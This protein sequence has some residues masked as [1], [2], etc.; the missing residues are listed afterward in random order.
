MTPLRPLGGLAPIDRDDSW[1]AQRLV[2]NGFT[3]REVQGK[4]A[5]YLERCPT[6]LAWMECT[7][8]EVGDRFFMAGGSTIQ[9]DGVYYWRNDASAYV[10]ECGATIPD[11]ALRTFES[12]AWGPPTFD[13]VGYIRIYEEL[14]ELLC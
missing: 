12:R 9:S 14:C 7:R 6:F 8:D 4:V 13:R 11:E 10:K 5:S 2:L 1:S 3:S